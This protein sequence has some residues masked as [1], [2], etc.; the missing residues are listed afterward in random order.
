M[1]DVSSNPGSAP[2]GEPVFTVAQLPRH[3]ATVLDLNVEYMSWLFDEFRG[4]FGVDIAEVLGGSAEA[5]VRAKLDAICG[6]QPPAGVFYLVTIDGAPAGMGGLRRLDAA[7]CEIKRV[8]V[9]PVFRGL[10][11][12]DRILARLLEEGRAFGYR[13]A[14]LESGPFMTSA[15]RAYARHGFVERPAYAEAEVPAQFHGRWRFMERELAPSP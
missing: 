4:H 13:H 9:R 6:E 3:R 5:Y 10:R 11:L 8:F 12:G 2:P 15:H 7:T 14:R 1:P